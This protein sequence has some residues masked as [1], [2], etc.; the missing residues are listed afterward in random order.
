LASQRSAAQHRVLDAAHTLIG[1][2]GF[3]GTSIQMIADALGVTKAA[4]YKQFHAKDD[5]AI[6]LTEREL[7]K[8]E[9]V[10]EAAENDADR[11]RARDLLLTA[12]VDLAVADR[13]WVGTLQFDP[14][15]IRLLSDHVPFRQFMTRLYQALVGNDGDDAQWA[16]A[17]L[18]GTISASVMH[19]LAAGL[20]DATLRAKLLPYVR[21]LVDMPAPPPIKR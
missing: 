10:L 15:I 17:V 7:G 11:V 20:D 19:P 3:S 5:I 18:S 13:R 9:P 8:L 21:R 4:V 1:E 12:V 6:A 16:G 2:Y 14:V